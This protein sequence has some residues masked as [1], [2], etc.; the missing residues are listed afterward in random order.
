MHSNPIHSIS[1]F[2]YSPQS[3]MQ[4]D[5][6]GNAKSTSH[7]RLLLKKTVKAKHAGVC[8][9]ELDEQ[10]RVLQISYE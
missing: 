9:M 4:Y 7:K 10:D 1:F 5:E 3:P 8:D 6:Q 2:G